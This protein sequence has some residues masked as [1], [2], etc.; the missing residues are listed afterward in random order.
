MNKILS[1]TLAFGIIG[2]SIFTPFTEVN[3]ASTT[4]AEALVKTAEQHAGALKWQISVELTKEIKYPDMKVF[5]S[6]KNAYL[7]AKKEIANVSAKDKAVLDKRLEENVGIHYKRAMGY[8][9]AI[10]SGKKIVDKSNQLN[11]LFATDPTADLTE[12]SYHELS[13][14]IRKQAALLYRVYGKSTREAI[15]TN[16]KTPGIRALNSTQ[17]VITA[18]MQ[19][20]TLDQLITNK[21]KKET[22]EK[23]VEK[24]ITL[25]DSVENDKIYFDLYD[26]YKESISKE[27]NFLAQQ[28]EIGDFFKKSTDY[29]NQENLDLTFSL[30]SE[31]FPG[32]LEL[33]ENIETSFKEFDVVYETLGLEIVYISNGEALVVQDQKITIDQQEFSVSKS[34]ILKKD[35]TGNW[36]YF[37]SLDAE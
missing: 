36:K 16:Y 18:K 5:N 13:S 14:E 37:E 7:T 15:L 11:K 3:A 28:I 27:P 6:T 32:Y 30:Y 4:K 20:D 26:S 9:D 22:V 2:A 24:L 23:H 34:Y 10:T 1:V 21:A 33:K 19:L 29:A 17:N 35:Q 25:L 8:I 31:E 12:N